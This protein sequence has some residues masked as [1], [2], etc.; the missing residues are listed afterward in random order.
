MRTYSRR[1]GETGE[2]FLFRNMSGVSFATRGN[3]LAR[4]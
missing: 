3:M 2:G 1:F 4:Q